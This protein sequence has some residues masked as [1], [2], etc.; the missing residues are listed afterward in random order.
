MSESEENAQ[1]RL[2]TSAEGLKIL[3]MSVSTGVVRGYGYRGSG[4]HAEHADHYIAIASPHRLRLLLPGHI[5][6]LNHIAPARH[7][8][9][10]G[11]AGRTIEW[12]ELLDAIRRG[13]PIA[14]KVEESLTHISWYPFGSW[15]PDLISMLASLSDGGGDETVVEP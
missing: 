6:Y 9:A 3:T 11:G 8:P 7:L 5:D 4:R 14:H 12:H 15:N 1:R 13:S 10:P 2:V